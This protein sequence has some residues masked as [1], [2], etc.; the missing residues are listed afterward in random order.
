MRRRGFAAT[1]HIFRGEVG[2]RLVQVNEGQRMY[3]LSDILNMHRTASNFGRLLVCSRRYC[4]ASQQGSPSSNRPGRIALAKPFAGAAFLRTRQLFDYLAHG[5]GLSDGQFVAYST[6]VL[7]TLFTAEAQRTVAP[8]SVTKPHGENEYL[9]STREPTWPSQHRTGHHL[10]NLSGAAALSSGGRRPR[11][12]RAVFVGE[13]SSCGWKTATH[14]QA[15]G[16]NTI[17][18]KLLN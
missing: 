16:Y 3:G 11:Y 2:G 17:T 12:K 13:N 14:F 5:D 4:H 18:A 7:R 10:V 6:A 9:N 1:A 8:P 15:S